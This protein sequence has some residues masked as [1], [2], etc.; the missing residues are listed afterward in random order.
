MT[1]RKPLSQLLPPARARVDG[2]RPLPLWTVKFAMYLVACPRAPSSVEQEQVATK[3]AN[4]NI[5]LTTTR[6]VTIGY[7][8]IKRL[9]TDSR[10]QELVRELEKGGIEAAKRLFTEDAPVYVMLHRMGAEEAWRN[11][12]YKALPAY[13]VPALDRVV[14]KRQEGVPVTQVAIVLSPERLTALQTYEAPETSV[15]ELPPAESADD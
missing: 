8:I 6:P 13:T 11:K 7:G 5:N 14:P 1:R 12:D 15:E 9:R 10:W 2:S 4:E 3:L